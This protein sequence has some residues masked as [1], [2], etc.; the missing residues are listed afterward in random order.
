MHAA[1]TQ[2]LV[3]RNVHWQS[4]TPATRHYCILADVV[5][6]ASREHM[7]DAELCSDDVAFIEEIHRSS[8]GSVY[9]GRDRR[10]GAA[11]ILKVARAPTI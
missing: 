8:G 3:D 11:V 1:A 5:A 6:N 7:R 9:T 2:R 4:D 10:T